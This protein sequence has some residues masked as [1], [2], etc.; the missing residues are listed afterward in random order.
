MSTGWAA[1]VFKKNGGKHMKIIQTPFG[2]R[3]VEETDPEKIAA[4]EAM[5]QS[6]RTESTGYAARIREL[7][8]GAEL[9]KHQAV[10]P[11][12]EPTIK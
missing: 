1:W 5:I 7:N 4:V 9:P 6:G 3:V 2:Q 11:R 8:G 10:K 12:G